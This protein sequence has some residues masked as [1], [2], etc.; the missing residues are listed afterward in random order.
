MN[1]LQSKYE[2]FLYRE[3]GLTPPYKNVVNFIDTTTGLTSLVDR[4]I[5]KEVQMI[6][7]LSM[8]SVETFMYNAD[9]RNRLMKIVIMDYITN[10]KEAF[11]LH[12]L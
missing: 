11:R 5:G 9:V 7:N 8:E 6:D 1:T 12:L 2:R 10:H 4:M 3:F